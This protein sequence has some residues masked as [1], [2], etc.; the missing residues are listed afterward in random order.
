MNSRNE[1][2]FRTLVNVLKEDARRM[3]LFLLKENVWLDGEWVPL[4][5]MEV[6][7]SKVEYIAGRFL[8]VAENWVRDGNR[9]RE[10][11]EYEEKV[12]L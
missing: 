5:E 6:A 8:L 7:F 2:V 3:F 1:Y 11:Y 4:G 12:Q 10:G 9:I